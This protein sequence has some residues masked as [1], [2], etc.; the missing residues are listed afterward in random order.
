VKL[1]EI[2]AEEAKLLANMRNDLPRLGELLETVNG[3]WGCEDRVYRFYH[4]SF[5]VFDLQVLTTRI[6]E[7]L[8]SLAPHLPLHPYFC[9][10]V[11]EGTRKQFTYE[12]NKRWT[13]ETRPIVEAFFHARYFLEMVCKYGNELKES[14][15][16]LPSGWAAVLELYG[17]R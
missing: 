16:S 14:P 10:I 1:A 12:M 7:A 5:K 2:Q 11:A 8:Q 15:T 6:V 13:K 9:E 17:L 3:H 4:S